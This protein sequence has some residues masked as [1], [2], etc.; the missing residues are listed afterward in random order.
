MQRNEIKKKSNPKKKERMERKKRK[1]GRKN[2][3]I[4]ILNMEVTEIKTKTKVSTHFVI[5]VIEINCRCFLD[6]DQPGKNV[7]R[8]LDA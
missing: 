3:N 6:I 1:G 7:F 2:K 5:K 8:R 4:N